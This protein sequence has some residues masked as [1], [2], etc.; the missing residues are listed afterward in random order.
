MINFVEAKEAEDQKV[1]KTK[2]FVMQ[3]TTGILA[4][5]LLIVG[6]MFGLWWYLSTKEERLTAEGLRL[7][8][9]I[10]SLS[11]NEEMIGKLYSR[12]NYVKQF[13]AGREDTAMHAQNA[14]G[15]AVPILKWD[16]Q[17][18]TIQT[19]SIDVESSVQ[20]EQVVQNLLQFY[21]NVSL[22]S[23]DKQKD[24]RFVAVIAYSAPK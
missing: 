1:L 7:V 3:A 2:K 19:I 16:Y 12:A 21:Q 5:Y 10:N 18:G 15:L 14:Y 8:G 4:I 24:G 11:S 20:A 17:V 9:R 13:L 23:L 6:G 22:T